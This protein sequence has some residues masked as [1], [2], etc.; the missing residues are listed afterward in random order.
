MIR[1]KYPT[2]SQDK[3]NQETQTTTNYT[4]KGPVILALQGEKDGSMECFLGRGQM[5]VYTGG[6]NSL[7]LCS[8]P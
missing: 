4:Q 7:S 6:G 5:E 1:P 8:Q 3:G 2:Q